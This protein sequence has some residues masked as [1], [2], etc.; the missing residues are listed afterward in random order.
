[1]HG[2]M[3][4]ISMSL[5]QQELRNEQELLEAARRG[6]QEAAEALFKEQRK[7]LTAYF[8]NRV[9]DGDAVEELV[10]EVLVSAY[11]S[12]SRFQGHSAVGIWILGIA[13][14]KLK[15]YY[16]RD[17]YKRGRLIHL[18]TRETE[19]LLTEGNRPAFSRHS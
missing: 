7:W 4:S 14:H 9:R 16:Q 18:D 3:M 8:R 2:R 15:N 12:L 17:P 19:K 10:Q 1:M 11:D 5:E 13:N 6:N